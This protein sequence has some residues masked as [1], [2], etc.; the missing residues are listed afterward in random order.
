M[1]RRWRHGN[2]GIS[3]LSGLRDKRDGRYMVAARGVRGQVIH[4][5]LRNQNIG[6]MTFSLS[7]L[8]TMRTLEAIA[9]H[10]ARQVRGLRLRG[11]SAARRRARLHRRVRRK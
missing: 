5:R 7:S 1:H 10:A 6:V 11:R 3:Q 4:A 9:V 8:G 2:G